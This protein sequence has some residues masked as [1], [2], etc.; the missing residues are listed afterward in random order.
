MA[1]SIGDDRAEF[2]ADPKPEMLPP[3]D[4][5]IFLTLGVRT[6]LFIDL[7]NSSLPDPLPVREEF[8]ALAAVT[9]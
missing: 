5:S 1:L 2:G 8:S 3:L 4:A 6:G 7:A 9:V